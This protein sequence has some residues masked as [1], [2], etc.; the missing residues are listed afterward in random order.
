ML[1]KN[2]ASDKSD[3]GKVIPFPMQEYN[4]SVHSSTGFTPSEVI[5]GRKAPNPTKL[6]DEFPLQIYGSYVCNLVRNLINIRN[7]ARENMISAKHRS[8]EYYDRKAM[9]QHLEVGMIMYVL[10]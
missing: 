10:K 3:W 4:T 7:V 2:H 6:A 8:K 1:V 9:P 5:Y